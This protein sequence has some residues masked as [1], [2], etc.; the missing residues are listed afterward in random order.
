MPAYTAFQERVIAERAEL[1]IN[2]AKLG[3]FLNTEVFKKVP[4]AEQ[5]RLNKQLS[6]MTEY[7][8]VLTERIDNFE[9]TDG[10]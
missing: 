1:D 7:S 2:R 3:K 9:L 10:E 6:I 5:E 4:I 8:N